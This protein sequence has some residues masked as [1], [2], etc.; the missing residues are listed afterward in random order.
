MHIHRNLVWKQYYLISA[1]KNGVLPIFF[2]NQGLISSRYVDYLDRFHMYTLIQYGGARQMF[3]EVMRPPKPLGELWQKPGTESL[4]PAFSTVGEKWNRFAHSSISRRVPQNC[5]L[6]LPN[7]SFPPIT[8]FSLPGTSH[9]LVL[10]ELH[11]PFQGRKG[12]Q[13]EDKMQLTMLE[14]SLKP[15]LHLWELAGASRSSDKTGIDAHKQSEI[16]WSQHRWTADHRFIRITQTVTIEKTQMQC[17][18]S[19]SVKIF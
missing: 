6:G 16:P 8:S 12:Q 17:K 5:V 4:L 2:A 9:L 3:P 19:L 15:V 11:F 14:I 10:L 13:P 18:S 1:R 7:I